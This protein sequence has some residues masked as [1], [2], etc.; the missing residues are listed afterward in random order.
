MKAIPP[1]RATVIR[2][3]VAPVMIVSLAA[4]T[5]V[6]VAVTGPADALTDTGARAATAIADAVAST[7]PRVQLSG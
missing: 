4:P 5:A 1:P 6:I 7:V 2:I 3:P